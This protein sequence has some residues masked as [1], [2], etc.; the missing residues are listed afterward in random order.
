MDKTLKET[1]VNTAID[2]VSQVNFGDI[3]HCGISVI[4]RITNMHKGVHLLSNEITQNK[5]DNELVDTFYNNSLKHFEK[6]YDKF[7][8]Y[9]S[10]HYDKNVMKLIDSYGVR[11]FTQH[12]SNAKRY[13][14]KTIGEKNLDNFIEQVKE[15]RDSYQTFIHPLIKD[16]CAYW[17]VGGTTYRRKKHERND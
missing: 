14:V 8:N 3:S 12:T 10:Q 17:K 13:F 4:D 1:L 11:L 7:I 16:L 6:T 2:E 15:V 9:I 5:K